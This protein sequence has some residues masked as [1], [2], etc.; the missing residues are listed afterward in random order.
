MSEL[1]N[2]IITDDKPGFRTRLKEELESL[3]ISVVGEADNGEQL[4]SL[5]KIITPDIVI[6][7][8]EMPIMDG[9]ATLDHIRVHHPDQ[10]IIILSL[11][12]SQVL[13]EDYKRRGAKGFI[14]KDVVT[15]DRE[16]FVAGI[17]K[18]YRGGTFFHNDLEEVLAEFSVRQ[19][20]I[21]QL[22]ASEKKAEEI[23]ETLDMTRSGIDRQKGKIMK[24]IGLDNDI[25]FFN[26]LW[27]KGLKY[28]SRP[29]KK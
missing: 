19:R 5:L 24:K 12:E 4:I 16:Y 17:K 2:V 3:E 26:Y 10:K 9:N 1:I 18:V 14:S 8:L 25:S 15:G 23:A 21:M 6:L 29:G 27:K 11:Y 7:D 20:E 28:L 22:I 13:L